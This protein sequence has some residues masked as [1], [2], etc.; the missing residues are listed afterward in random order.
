MILK[1]ICLNVIN[2]LSL[3]MDMFFLY[4]E[5]LKD[6][7]ISLLI[8]L[9]DKIHRNYQDMVNNPDLLVSILTKSFAIAKF[10]GKEIVEIAD[11]IEAVID[12]ER[13]YEFSK[14]RIT[15]AL[16]HLKCF[17]QENIKKTKIIKLNSKF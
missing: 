2:K 16:E 11:L 15:K 10:Y 17:D 4:N 5:Y 12:N 9:T 3:E 14:I 13:L 6:E 7:I 8:N 1:E